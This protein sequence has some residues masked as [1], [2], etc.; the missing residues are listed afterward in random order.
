MNSVGATERAASTANIP[1][2][3]KAPVSF[4]DGPLKRF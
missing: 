1:S 4:L 2:E 3:M